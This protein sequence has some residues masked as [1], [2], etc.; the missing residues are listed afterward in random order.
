VVP[1]ELHLPSELRYV[2]LGRLIVCAAARQAGMNGERI[3]DLRIAVSEAT[4]NAMLAQR[5]A[6]PSRPVVLHFG[7][8][9]GAFEV[10]VVDT[11]PGFEPAP[12]HADNGR[13]WSVEGGL[14][15]TIIREL[16]DDVRFVREEGMRVSIRFAVDLPQKADVAAS[17]RGRG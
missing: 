7:A 5:R 8:A 14:G 10:T 17:I 9:D 15:V 6:D 1:I 12:A 4:T 2:G 13:D 16:A 11:G 3:E